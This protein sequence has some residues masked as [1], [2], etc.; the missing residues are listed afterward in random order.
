MTPL[1]HLTGTFDEDTAKAMIGVL[2][3]AGYWIAPR[4]LTEAMAKRA[5][6]SQ[7][8]DRL[9]DGE[10]AMMVSALKRQWTTFRA[11]WERQQDGSEAQ[12]RALPQDPAE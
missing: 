1:E 12:G 8:G 6:D 7:P 10:V 5:I 2:E 3:L 9:T 11:A 4:E